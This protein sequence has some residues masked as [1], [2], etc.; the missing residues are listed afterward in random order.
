A[1]GALSY[2]IS[3]ALPSFEASLSSNTCL[4]FDLSSSFLKAL[5]FLMLAQA[6]ECFWQSAANG[7]RFCVL[8]NVLCPIT[9]SADVKNML[10][11]K[12]AAKTAN[13]YKDALDMIDSD[14]IVKSEFP[15]VRP[16]TCSIVII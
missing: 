6:Q 3:T 5:Q 2:L 4:P 11:A 12:L 1:A 13:L 7:G 8:F 16:Y 10:V 9:R 15:Q 14:R